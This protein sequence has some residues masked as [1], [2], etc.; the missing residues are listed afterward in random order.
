MTLKFRRVLR[1]GSRG[2]D[3]SQLQGWLNKHGFSCGKIDG[4]Y[5]DLTT[6]AVKKFQISQR[7]TADRIAGSQTYS[8]I[9]N[10]Q[11]WLQRARNRVVDVVHKVVTRKR[12]DKIVVHHSASAPN[13]TS[14]KI[15]YGWHRARGFRKGGYSAIVQPDGLIQTGDVYPQYLRRSNEIGAHAK[16]HNSNS[17]G[18]CLI[19]NTT[20]TK[21]QYAAVIEY[22]KGLKASGNGRLGI[23]GHKEL[24]AATKCPGK[25]DMNYIR[26]NV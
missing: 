21:E 25:T 15:I 19:T 10:Y 12:W 18:I 7:I 9:N 22:I 16:G 26:R 11:N 14:P 1:K 5:G 17:Y 24:P 13:Y 3:V 20:P 6:A 4:I 8:A 2:N 23:F